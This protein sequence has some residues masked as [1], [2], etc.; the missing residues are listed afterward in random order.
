MRD[1]GRHD[2]VGAL[3]LGDNADHRIHV[4]GGVAPVTMDVDVPQGDR[5]LL[6]GGDPGD[7]LRDFASNERLRPVRG[8][9]VVKHG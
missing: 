8:F 2:V 1:T 4:V 3:G 9:V 6:V 5:L 7:G